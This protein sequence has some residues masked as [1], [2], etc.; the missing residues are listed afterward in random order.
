MLKLKIVSSWDIDQR[1]S[2]RKERP[3]FDIINHNLINLC[4]KL[5]IQQKY[6]FSVQLDR[7]PQ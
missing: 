1:I 4:I 7:T 2:G 6:K 3:L 5:V